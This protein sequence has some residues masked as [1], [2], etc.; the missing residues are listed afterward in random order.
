MNDFPATQLIEATHA[1]TSHTGAKA[2]EAQPAASRVSSQEGGTALPAGLSRHGNSHNAPISSEDRLEACPTLPRAAR[3][4]ATSHD[5]RAAEANR[6]LAALQSFNALL[7]EGCTLE[8]ALRRVGESRT[9]LWRWQ[10]RFEA[11]G[12]PGLLP[13]TDKCGRKSTLENL[14][15]PQEVLDQVKGIKLDTGSN[16]AAW[17]LFA[18]SDR[19]P[20]ALARVVLD[21]N[22]SSKHSLPP[23][24][25]AAT[26]MNAN[27]HN[28][29]R[30]PRRLAL[31]GFYIPRKNDILPGDIF[32]SDDT[33]PIWGWWVP[34]REDKDHPFGV[35]LMQGQFLPVMDVASQAI[36]NFALIAREKGSYRAS[37]IWALFG[38]T[39]DTVGLPRLGWQLERGSWESN[40]IRG[41]EVSVDV[42]GI[43]H[44]RR[45]GGLRQLPTNITPWHR[46]KL[47]ADFA[48]PSTLQTYTSYLPKS[49]SIEAAFNRM[50]T[51]E[52]TLWGSLGRDQ[53]RNPYE[54][55]KKL[56]Q[57]CQRGA[58]DPRHHFLSQIEMANRLRDILNYVN[59]EPMEGEVFAGIPRQK[60]DTGLAENPLFFLPEEQRYLYRSDWKAITITQGIARIRLTHEISGERYS[61]FYIN[62]RVFAE[63]EGQAVLCYYDRTNFEA[64]AQIHDA[65]TGEFICEAPSEDR[66]GSFLDGDRSGHDIAK[67]WKN[68]VMTCYSAIAQ[69]APSKQLPSEIAARR[70]VGCTDKPI[71]AGPSVVDARP[72][73]K[74]PARN[75]RDFLAAPTP[76]QA[77]RRSERLAEEAED[78][79][80]LQAI[81]VVGT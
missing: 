74:G 81:Q 25:R 24:L 20:E 60:F 75:A 37:D 4:A 19:C 65:R 11:E 16:T 77:R 62:P 28:A 56:F 6:R 61:L 71:A 43:S 69:H 79:R 22:K 8:I 12:F 42:H 29:H 1:M 36:I 70:S 55:T 39:F 58:E 23:S 38:H 21:P 33:T 30:G 52:G 13:R 80:R 26:K 50:Q 45:I 54:K 27:L 67:Q 14:A 32:T 78:A 53:M 48:F 73:A 31:K 41:Q 63:I 59:S 64:A 7:Q 72:A 49:K 10:T 18:N 9:T 2:P 34:W 47:G 44:D 40:L 76:E 3:T 51:F 66:R 17:R 46:E 35:K 5:Y 57:A 15:V 68:A